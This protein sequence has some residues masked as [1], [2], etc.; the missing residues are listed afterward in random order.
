MAKIER[1]MMH[2]QAQLGKT[3][4]QRQA[5]P[6]GKPP[7]PATPPKTQLSPEQKMQFTADLTDPA[8]SDQAITRLF[9]NATG[10]DTTMMI[11][12]N[13]ARVCEAWQEGHPEFYDHPANAKLIADNATMR[14]GG[15]KNVT[16][17]ALEQVYQELNAGGFLI[18]RE[19]VAQDDNRST[20]AASPEQTPA[21]RADSRP[22]KNFATGHRSV[23]LQSGQ[24]VTW[25]P[26][27]TREQINS[28]PL[29]Q[30]ERL[31]RTNDPDYA[32]AVEHWYPS[33]S[34]ASA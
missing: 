8:K 21:L 28:M 11:A 20:P 18:T 16:A 25:T 14:C 24:S 29:V 1:T 9:E 34:R 27:Y 15:L 12:E 26:K 5:Q 6:N 2:A 22:P 7:A 30:S 19:E 3:A 23:R 10:V 17:A 32:A 31:L 4:P 33:R 13:F